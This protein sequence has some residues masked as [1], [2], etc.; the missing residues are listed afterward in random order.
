MRRNPAALP[1]PK[2]APV[3]YLPRLHTGTKIPKTADLPP[4]LQDAPASAAGEGRGGGSASDSG[5]NTT[6][7]ATPAI[8]IHLSARCVCKSPNSPLPR[9]GGLGWGQQKKPHSDNTHTTTPLTYT[10]PVILYVRPAIACALAHRFLPDKA[11][12]AR[13]PANRLSSPCV[14]GTG[15]GVS[16]HTA[17]AESSA[18]LPPPPWGRVGVGAAKKPHS[19]NTHSTTPFTYTLSAQ[20]YINRPAK[21]HKPEP[22]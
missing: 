8:Y 21:P 11:T 5:T 2:C 7:P 10:F 3:R 4:P 12:A 1:P 18:A 14:G 6:S 19:D 20:V 13:I 15:G 16:R 17:N 9:G 22:P